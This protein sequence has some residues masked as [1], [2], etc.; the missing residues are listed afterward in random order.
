VE[1]YVKTNKTDTINTA[2]IA[3][4][5]TRPTMRL[6]PIKHEEKLDLHNL[7]RIRDLR[8]SSLTGFISRMR[9]FCLRYGLSVR[10]SPAAYKLPIHGITSDDTGDLT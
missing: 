3:E 7:H 1:P 6:V 10:T 2:A 8:V 4:A 5:V 9:A